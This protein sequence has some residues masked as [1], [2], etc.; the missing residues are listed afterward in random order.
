[1]LIQGNSEKKTEWSKLQIEPTTLRSQLRVHTW[2]KIP[3]GN[4][5]KTECSSAN[6]DTDNNDD[7]GND[8]YHNDNDDEVNDADDDKGKINNHQ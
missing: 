5:E 8:N 4:S 6:D 2:M 7:D 3:R 1:M